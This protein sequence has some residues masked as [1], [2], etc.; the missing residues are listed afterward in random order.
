MNSATAKKI[1]KN[2]FYTPN[3]DQQYS[4]DKL[5]AIKHD[6][7]PV[8]DSSFHIHPVESTQEVSEIEKPKRKKRKG[9]NEN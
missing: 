3:D 5:N 4:I 2:P 1:S 8:H 6:V 9:L 7:L